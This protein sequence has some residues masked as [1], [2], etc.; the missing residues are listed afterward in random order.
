MG[1]ND[2][3]K[4]DVRLNHVIQKSIESRT[5]S[6]ILKKIAANMVQN[7][8]VRCARYGD[9]FF[10]GNKMVVDYI[11]NI[12]RCCHGYALLGEIQN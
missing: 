3:G 12:V 7:S 10:M 6:G 2:N 4:N 8:K 1:I 9:L 5:W 11:D